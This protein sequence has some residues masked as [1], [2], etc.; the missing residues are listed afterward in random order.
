MTSGQLDLARAWDGAIER[1][2][3][4]EFASATFNV[5]LLTS[6]RPRWQ[7]AVSPDTSMFR[8]LFNR[9]GETFFGFT[10]RVHVEWRTGERVEMALVRMVPRAS[11][12]VPLGPV[13]VTGDFTRPLNA[14]P[15]VEALLY[16]LA[17]PG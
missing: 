11:G 17:D 10:E 5:G 8:L 1:Y 13:I 4:L 12:G 9:P 7:A 14:L 2:I 3:G 16:Q 6:L 15:A